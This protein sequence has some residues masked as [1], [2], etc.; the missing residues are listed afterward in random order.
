M[1]FGRTL[2]ADR[3]FIPICKLAKVIANRAMT[4]GITFAAYGDIISIREP[5]NLNLIANLT[6][7]LAT[8]S[9]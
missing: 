4:L 2:G 5:V 1:M 6:A 7:N 3:D 8:V 9:G